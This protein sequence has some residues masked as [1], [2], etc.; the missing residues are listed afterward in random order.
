MKKDYL[1]ITVDGR[2]QKHEDILR[3]VN[4]E[5]VLSFLSIIN[6]VFGLNYIKVKVIKNN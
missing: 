5:A 6:D 3:D 2:N 1:V 4:S